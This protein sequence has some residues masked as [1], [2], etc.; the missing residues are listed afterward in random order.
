MFYIFRARLLR[1]LALGPP[2]PGLNGADDEVV[3]QR[4]DSED[5]RDKVKLD[6]C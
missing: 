2:V 6:N 4:Y 1:G 3:R 5:F